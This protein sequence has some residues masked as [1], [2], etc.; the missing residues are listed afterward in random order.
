M[1]HGQTQIHIEAPPEKVYALISDVT[2]MGEWSPECYR[3]VWL[4]GANGAAPG[5]RFRGYNKSNWLRWSRLVEVRVA[6]PGKEFAFTTLT[7]FI[8]KDSTNWRYTF[9]P[10]N[11]GTLLTESYEVTR[12]PSL[13]IKIIGFLSRRPHDMGPHMETTLSR[14][15]SAAEKETHSVR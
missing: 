14:I 3:C 6:D 15:K 11:G 10:S 12:L 8:N 5:A 13:P 2:R 7:D 1:L 4:N 9:E